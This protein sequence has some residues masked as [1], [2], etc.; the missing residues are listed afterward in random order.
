MSEK[1]DGE[2]PEEREEQRL[3][4]LRE[5]A[6]GWRRQAEEYRAQSLLVQADFENYRRRVERDLAQNIRRGKRRLLLGILGVVDNFERA[7]NAGGDVQTLR[8]GVEIIFRQLKELLAAEG[9]ASLE[10]VGQEFDP[11]RH[12]AVEVWESL[13]ADAER[14][15]EELQKGYTY[16]GELLRPARVRVVRPAPPIGTA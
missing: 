7:L 11:A 4:A 16:E 6:D 10:T 1:G 5:E 9:V 8:T 14:V 2:L 15:S 13:D 12:E 3:E